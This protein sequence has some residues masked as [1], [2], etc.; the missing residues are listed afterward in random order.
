[1][2]AVERAFAW[3]A[4]R[5]YRGYFL[6]GD[7][8]VPAGEKESEPKKYVYNYIFLPSERRLT[9]QPSLSAALRGVFTV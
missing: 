8:L 9:V 1:M 2:G 6:H 4:A 7:V 5:Q 3:F